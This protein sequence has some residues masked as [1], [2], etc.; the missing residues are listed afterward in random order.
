MSAK[1]EY[2]RKYRKVVK[3]ANSCCE[4]EPPGLSNSLTD[5]ENVCGL[6][7]ISDN[8]TNYILNDS[9]ELAPWIA[10]RKSVA[11]NKFL[12]YRK[13]VSLAKNFTCQINQ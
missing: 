7:S 6:S 12:S 11:K 4:C 10:Y 2:M 3:D 13:S 9:Y 8:S 5:A 1:A